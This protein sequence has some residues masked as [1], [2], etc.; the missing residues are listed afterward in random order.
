MRVL[1][2][3]TLF[4]SAGLL[5]LVEPMFAKMVLPLVGGTPA[6]WNTCL[7]FFQ[8][9]LLAGYLWAHLTTERIK[10]R[11]QAAVQGA[12]LIAPLAVLPIRLP[13]GWSPPAASNPTLWIF[14][15]AVLTV[16]L[17][18]FVLAT[19]APTLQRW[20]AEMG[21]AKG[22]DPYPLYRASNFGSLLALLSYPF[23]LEPLLRLNAQGRVWAWGYALL[24]PL[25]LCCV[26]LF[27]RS[28]PEG[29]GAGPAASG[30]AFDTE[31]R[32]SNKLRLRW[33]ALAFVPASLLLGVTTTLTTDIPPIPFLWV[34]P[35][36]I[37]LGTFILVFADRPFVP[38]EL[39][40]ERL[41]FLVLAATFTVLARVS[42]PVILLL[43]LHW[44]TF[45]VAAM[46][47]HGELARSRPPAPY[48]THFYLCL[49]FGGVL[50]GLFNALVAPLVF[51]SVVEYPLGLALA[52]FC[53]PGLERKTPK[54]SAKWL[55]FGLPALLGLLCVALVRGLPALGL[56][57]QQVLQF[58]TF[59]PPLLLCLSFGRRP[60]R[61]ALGVAMLLVGMQG[62]TGPYGRELHTAR[63]FFGV[64]RVMLDGDGKH[65]LLFH[66]STI[67]GM[68]SIGPADRRE[69][70]AYFHRS[71]PIGQ[72]FAEFEAAGVRPAV[73][74]VGLGAGSLAG[75][76][77]PGQAFTFYEI[78]P[79]VERLARDSRYF[80]FLRDCPGNVRVVL[81]DARL[82]LR[83]APARGYGLLVL[84]AFSSDSIP[85][86]LL[87]REALAL[88]LTKLD[89]GGILALHISNRYLD[90]EPVLANLARD[91]GLV[92]WMRDDTAVSAE[93]SRN[94]KFPAR[95]VVLA[96]TP[97]EV[98]GLARDQRW[99]QLEARPRVGL[100][101][102]DFSNL[103]TI[104]RWD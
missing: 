97:G 75:Y 30:T 54:L 68:Q 46:V 51:R 76:A 45:F 38:H 56:R 100:W 72:V 22:R 10:A 14:A 99:K 40:V 64:Y 7:V 88:Y 11:R 103:F 92:G 29:T 94:G 91:A 78:D 87:T 69:P 55:D 43:P 2:A 23:L 95:W 96:R 16:G 49:A 79:L 48:L 47:C 104:L 85:M 73:G 26:V 93:E 21:Q 39:M 67:H 83:D 70:L 33:V 44:L 24:V 35:L 52:A 19:M 18:F 9:T 98:R 12:L 62:Y 66:G 27:S 50:G 63:S 74:I 86:H 4:V 80:T 31:S 32:V 77:A 90:L 3:L 60:L 42:L 8:A 5:F 71:G 65:V 1:F 102:D 59:V 36:A 6:V 20:Y 101:T 34:V 15:L 81:G 17:P 41:P 13:A 84:D 53:R 37:Y 61:F 89:D 58:L 25:V 57:N 28:L 82:S